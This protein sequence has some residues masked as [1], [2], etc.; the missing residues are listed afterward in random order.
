VANERKIVHSLVSELSQLYGLTLDPNPCLKRRIRNSVG[1]VDKGHII[2]V[3]RAALQGLG[4]LW[5]FPLPPHPPSPRALRKHLEACARLAAMVSQAMNVLLFLLVQRHDTS[6]SP[7]LTAQHTSTG[8]AMAIMKK[9]FWLTREMHKMF[10]QY[11]R[12]QAVCKSSY[13]WGMAP[14]DNPPRTA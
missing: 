4:L 8:L 10:S 1:T 3:G 12:G 11:G 6:L 14:T 5:I 9:T 13:L 7:T 2:V